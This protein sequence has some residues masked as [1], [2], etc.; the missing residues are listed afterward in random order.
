MSAAPDR[1]LVVSVRP[2][3]SRERHLVVD[4]LV[5]LG[6]R[7]VEERDGALT[8]H[9]P[10][11]DDP[12][13]FVDGVRWRLRAVPGVG[14]SLRVTWAWQAHEEWA[15]L[16]KRDLAPRR[17]SPRVV[18]TPTW[19]D[20]RARPSDLVIRLD[21]GVAFGT[22]EHATTRGCLRLLDG[23]VASGERVADLG[24]GSGILAIAACGLGAGEVVAVDDDPLECAAAR[25]NVE[26]NGCAARVRVVRDLLDAEGVADLGPLDGIVAN[27]EAGV[28]GR[29]LP[30]CARAVRRGGWT[31]LSG[32][33]AGERGEIVDR[34]ERLGFRP[35]AEDREGEWWSGLLRRSPRP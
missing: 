15:E 13:A 32:I 9:F 29:L 5:G 6:A 12:E 22:A 27:I 8:T 28:L 18:V 20:A 31:I 24:T 35:E 7:A 34:A 19:L 2:A 1:W 23:T 21:P 25:E 10:P 16:W 3:E 26:A 30:G 4:A 11:P 17:I 14:P 33:L